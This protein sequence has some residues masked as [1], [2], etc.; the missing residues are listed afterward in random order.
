MKVWLAESK[1]GIRSAKPKTL[2]LMVH[3]S[4][5][6]FDCLQMSIESLQDKAWQM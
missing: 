6:S 4:R 3:F 1:V 2:E 5:C